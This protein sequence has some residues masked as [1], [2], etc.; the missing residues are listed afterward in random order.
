MAWIK[1]RHRKY[2]QLSTR[3]L[4]IF[5]SQLPGQSLSLY[6]LCEFSDLVSFQLFDQNDLALSPSLILTTPT[7]LA[8]GC[9]QC[10][11]VPFS[12]ISYANI[13]WDN[14][15]FVQNHI[16]PTHSAVCL[17]AGEKKNQTNQLLKEA[18]PSFS[19]PHQNTENGHYF[20]QARCKD[21]HHALD[22]HMW[23]SVESTAALNLLYKDIKRVS[24]ESNIVCSVAFFPS[25]G[26]H[27]G[28]H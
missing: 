22:S 25:L 11:T 5:N 16:T 9:A 4:F 20:L 13:H 7:T 8:L 19:T 17:F 18:P 1:L 2:F 14:S 26:T 6:Y 3:V 27:Y 15:I 21:Q 24:T 10:A 28:L 12:T 23:F